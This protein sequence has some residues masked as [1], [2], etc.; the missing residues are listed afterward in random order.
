M[1]GRVARRAG[2]RRAGNGRDGRSGGVIDRGGG[3]DRGGLYVPPGDRGVAGGEAARRSAGRDA[4]LGLGEGWRRTVAHE[5]RV[6][7]LLVLPRGSNG[8]GPAEAASGPSGWFSP[9]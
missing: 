4:D 1:R 7:Y 6:V 3:R 5:D 2:G 8:M 9:L